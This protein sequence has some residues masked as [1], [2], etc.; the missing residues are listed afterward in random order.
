MQIKYIKFALEEVFYKNKNFKC[1]YIS[2]IKEF[3]DIK[4]YVNKVIKELEKG[5]RNR[6]IGVLYKYIYEQQLNFLDYKN[7]DEITN[8]NGVYIIA[9]SEGNV[10]YIGKN[11]KQDYDVFTRLFDHFVPKR[12][13]EY[14][15]GQVNNNTPEIWNNEIKMNR[16]L[17]I[18]VC[19]NINFNPESLKTHLLNKYKL[20]YGYYPKYTEKVPKQVSE[21]T[22]FDNIQ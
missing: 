7:Y 10:L 21:E 14:P 5:K 18:V 20:K 19:T 16:N 13:E 15:R 2:E 8:D 22:L 17:K 4:S 6:W 12:S 11:E 9:D 1:E 3:K